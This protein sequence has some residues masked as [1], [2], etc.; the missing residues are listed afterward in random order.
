MATTDNNSSSRRRRRLT[1]AERYDVFCD[2]V[3]G[4]GS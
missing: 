2:I 1:V 4:A 3:S